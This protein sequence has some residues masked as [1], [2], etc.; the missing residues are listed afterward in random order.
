[1]N[2]KIFNKDRKCRE[3]RVDSSY[4]D[5]QGRITFF[6]SR[7]TKKLQDAKFLCVPEVIQFNLFVEC[8]GLEPSG[9]A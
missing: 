6:E 1:M 9:G 8:G 2:Y 5:T 4:E 7:N 3:I